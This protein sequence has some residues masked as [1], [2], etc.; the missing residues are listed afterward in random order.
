MCRPLVPNGEGEI[1]GDQQMSHYPDS[2]S[3]HVEKLRVQLLEASQR[4]LETSSVST[5]HYPVK[6]ELV[7][8]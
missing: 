8:V 1:I 6:R 7:S 3:D 4:I 2:A 5:N